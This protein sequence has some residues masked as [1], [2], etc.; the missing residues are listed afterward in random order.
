M[1]DIKTGYFNELG[2][3]AYEMRRKVFIEE[4]GIPN[5]VIEVIFDEYDKIAA[6]LVLFK[7]A[8]RW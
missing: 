7:A 5:E 6:H 4:Q 1:T 2:E 8:M 3:A